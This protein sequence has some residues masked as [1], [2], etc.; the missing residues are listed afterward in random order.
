LVRGFGE[1]GLGLRSRRSYE[2]YIEME[3]DAVAYVV[4]ACPKDRLEPYIWRFPIVGDFPYKGFFRLEDAKEERAILQEEGYDVRISA[5]AAFSALGWFPDPLY[6]PMLR[7]EEMDLVYTILHEMVH[8]TV[9]FPDH[10]DF[11]EQ[12]ATLVGWQG[13][14]AF[15]EGKHGRDSIEAREA[16]DTIEDERSFAQFLVWAHA[17][18]SEFY[19]RSIPR[20][21]K[22]TER[23][24]VYDEILARLR[25]LLPQLR[26]RRFH[27]TTTMAWNNASLLA[28]WRYRYNTGEL[29]ALFRA[30]NGDLRE[31]V[32]RVVSWKD[33]GTRPEEGLRKELDGYK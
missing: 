26:T 10:V 12:L 6:A 33:E 24:A 2:T 17:H 25:A 22:V 4:S 1:A 23:A 20:E 8:S 9:F 30:L 32:A 28:L 21:E 29:D 27:G 5:A 31:L 3:G 13:A 16:G 11:N 14:V 15:A 7:M 19:S 18:V